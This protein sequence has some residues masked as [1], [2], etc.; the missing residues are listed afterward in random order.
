MAPRRRSSWRRGRATHHFSGH[1]TRTTNPRGYQTTTSYQTFDSPSYDAP[2]AISE[3]GGVNTSID[4][5]VFGAHALEFEPQHHF[6]TPQRVH[7]LVHQLDDMERVEAQ[8]RFRQVL[9]RTGNEV[10]GH[11]QAD[12][13]DLRRIPYRLLRP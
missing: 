3:P 4:R 13:T 8:C 2:T 5:D 6:R 9:A 11:V 10:L 1:R 12:A 7:R